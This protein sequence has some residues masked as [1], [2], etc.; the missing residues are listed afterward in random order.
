[1]SPLIWDEGYT[2]V[3]GVGGRIVGDV[4][5]GNG[6]VY[7]AGVTTPVP[8][9][10]GN[11]RVCE[12]ADALFSVSGSGIGSYQ[13][14]VSTDGGSSFSN[15][16]NGS[17]VSGA[18]S[19]SLVLGSVPLLANGNLHMCRVSGSGGNVASLVQRLRV[20][21]VVGVP[22]SVVAIPAGRQCS[23]TP[24]TYVASWAGSQVG[25]T[26][27]WT[28]NGVFAGSGT[29][30]VRSDLL[31]GD[32]VEVNLSNS[33]CELGTGQ[34]AALVESLP[35]IQSVSGGGSYCAGQIGSVVGLLG[36]QV[37]IRYVLLLNGS[38]TGDTIV[39]VGGAIDFGAQTIAGTYSVVA[40][41]GLG[42]VAV[43]SGSAQ[44]DVLP[45]VV[46]AVT[47]DTTIYA[48]QSLQLLASGGTSYLW[49]PATG[50]SNVN[51]ANPVASPTQT[52]IYTVIIG[53]LFGCSDTLQVVVTVVPTPAV[54]AGNDTVVCIN[55]DT[56]RLTGTPAG[57]SWN[58]VG[59]VNNTQGLFVASVAGVG[60]H[61]VVYT[62]S[63]AGLLS[64]DTVRIVTG[65]QI[66][67][68]HV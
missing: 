42:C 21:S 39:G 18:Q 22:V 41:S 5:L 14:M 34:V 20:D 32:L 64:S 66:G 57:G 58:G 8:S 33:V 11:Q 56:V 61:D 3:T 13:W 9:S 67:R 27:R 59:I 1:M 2:Q 60:T 17:G 37:G 55:A 48:G 38:T 36:S 52:T 50:L 35:A 12:F 62:I 54:S 31:D 45:A 40:V 29:T 30:L 63:T 49:S 23:G 25:T 15:L 28:V 43:M 53:N 47:S 7:G 6:L 68:A 24:V 44:V 19:A 4:R 26:Y 16:S 46:G 65:K 10:N 51:I